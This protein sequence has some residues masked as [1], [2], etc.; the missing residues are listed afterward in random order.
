MDWGSD[1]TWPPT[2]KLSGGFSWR[3]RFTVAIVFV[4]VCLPR[5]GKEGGSASYNRVLVWG[6]SSVG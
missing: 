2:L 4:E 5:D 3:S 1:T 6:V